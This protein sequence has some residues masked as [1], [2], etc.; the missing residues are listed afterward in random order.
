MSAQAIIRRYKRIIDILESGQHPS[1]EDIMEYTERIGLKA[2]KRTIER[3]FEAIRNDFNIEI[4]YN[5]IKRG[6]FI[7]KEESLSIDNFLRLLELVETAHI[8]QENL[9]E[10][11][12]TLSYIDFEYEG[13]ASGVEFLQD[14]L[15]AIRTHHIIQFNH[16]SYQTGKTQSYTV[17]PYLIKEYQGRWYVIGEVKDRSEFRTFGMDRIDTLEILTDTFT[18]KKN[19]NLKER[20]HDVVGL[21]YSVG[22]LQKIIL[23]VKNS[24]IPYLNSV[25]LHSSQRI[26]EEKENETF[27]ELLLKP[28]YEFLQRIFMQ[29]DT[30]RVIE[31]IS[32]E[33]EIKARLE[34]MKEMY[35]K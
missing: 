19:T 23:A 21:T 15:Q 8:F 9:K 16:K 7:N 33:K 11:K 31:P 1:M 12:K 25:P 28:N 29:M 34:R 4:E 24:Q 2:S 27:I 17:K 26:I 10:S 30:V 35:V 14:V 22:K 13:I 20:F 5:K 6:Y 3:D 18:P 32:L